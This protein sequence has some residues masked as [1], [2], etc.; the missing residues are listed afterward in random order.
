[1]TI[2]HQLMWE[3]KT[4][5]G[6]LRD[7][8][9]RYT[10]YDTNSPDGNK[11]FSS[12]YHTC[13]TSKRCDTEKFTQDVN[14]QGLCGSK[15][16]RLPDIEQLNSLV[17][18]SN[19]KY[20]PLASDQT[21]Y[22]CSD[23]GKEPTINSGY[24]PNTPFPSGFCWSSSS[25]AND[26]YGAWSVNF[27]RGYDY[28]DFKDGIGQVRLVRIGQWF[29]VLSETPTPGT[30]VSGNPTAATFLI[31]STAD[32]G[33]SYSNR[34][35]VTQKI[36][37]S[38]K[39][40][41]APSHIGRNGVTYIVANYNGSWYMKSP[42]GW[43]VWDVNTDSLKASG[44][45]HALSRVEVVDIEKSLSGLAG[46]FAVY[47]GYKV[48]SDIQYNAP[49][50]TFTVPCISPQ[51]VQNGVCV[52]PP[53]SGKYTKI[54]SNGNALPDSAP[55]WDCAKDN[56]TGLMWE[57]KTNDGGLRDQKWSYTWYDSNSPDGN[58]GVSSR[59]SYCKT[60]GRCDTEKFTQDVNAQGL[61]GSKDW[62]MPTIEELRTVVY[63]SA[64]KYSG[65]DCLNTT[66]RPTIDSGY[67][68]NT[69]SV[70]FWSS[71][72][73]AD[74]SGFA[75]G[76]YFYDGNDYWIFKDGS[77]LVRLVRIGQ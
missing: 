77:S 55:S 7:Q 3:V 68:P 71:S 38:G 54:D 34:F 67:F 51:V 65:N 35:N 26:S 20:N 66:K 50:Y 37:M 12:G 43:A 6:G 27:S 15:D 64:G 52:N 25:Y 69:L 59:T 16:W 61:C 28:V 21:G 9:W 22:I 57:V 31:Q 45:A 10:W 14:T 24:F 60:N 48:D 40:S 19:G 58:K 33:Q 47:L 8:E 49:A 5:D 56:A 36:A 11:G 72:S 2:R 32:A 17:Y 30:T 18:C 75:R 76:V 23:Y 73:N 44:A 46:N 4:T 63:C 13:K 74:G 29:G 39:I 42:Q 1:M 70:V 62:R 41:V 53:L